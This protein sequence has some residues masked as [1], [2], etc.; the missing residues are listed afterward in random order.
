MD[1]RENFYSKLQ[2]VRENAE[3]LDELRG[4]QGKKGQKLLDKVQRRAAGR[5][6]KAAN[7]RDAKSAKRNQG[8]AN[9]AWERM[10]EK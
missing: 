8:V 3:Q 5:M 9:A 6:I 10:K 1:I 2:Q 7:S 4:Y